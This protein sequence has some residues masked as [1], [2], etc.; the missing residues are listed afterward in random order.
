MMLEFQQQLTLVA[1]AV[2]HVTGGD[3]LCSRFHCFHK[4]AIRVLL[5]VEISLHV[6][7]V[8]RSCCVRHVALNWVFYKN[9]MVKMKQLFFHTNTA[10]YYSI[11]IRIE[12]F[13]MT[14]WRF[15]NYTSRSGWLSSFGFGK[16]VQNVNSVGNLLIAKY[17]LLGFLWISVYT[18]AALEK[19][20]T[21][22]L[23]HISVYYR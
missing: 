16:N 1:K 4:S 3:S 8:E 17:P 19:R 21:W 2:K 9:E 23:Q 7:S 20:F 13:L 22:Y 12:V 10:K 15:L 5:F 14:N 6:Q 11:N 18:G